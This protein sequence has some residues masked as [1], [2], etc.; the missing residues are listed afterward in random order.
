MGIFAAGAFDASTLTTVS[1]LA[2]RARADD[3]VAPFSDDL[4]AAVTDGRTELTLTL[5][6]EGKVSG[7]AFTA[8]QGD[9]L[10]AEL[11]VDPR[12]RRRGLG[13]LLVAQLLERTDGE[14][15]LWAHGDLPGA[16]V[17]AGRH[18]LERTRELLQLRRP[19]GP[20]APPLPD[21][22]LPDGVRI[23]TFVVGQDEPAWLEVNNAAFSWHPEQSG[24]TMDD[25][26][27]A[28]SAADFDPAGFFLAVDETDRI[29][30]FHWTKVHAHDPAAPDSGPIGEVYVVGVA[31][32]AHGRGLGAALTTTG[33][34]H[35][36][37]V[38]GV[39]TVQLYVEG[40]NAAALK[41]YERT[42]FARHL[43]DIAYRRG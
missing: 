42:G 41:V 6:D 24:Q 9:R 31:P 4:W 32:E 20:G 30:G 34:R 37:E 18:Q 3:G 22:R 39:E 15:W 28:E 7:V 13:G 2:D 10:A 40:D 38:A 12:Q 33:L 1:E 19:W 23:R 21:V 11:V 17:L 26:R 14:L 29:L 16:R 36:A 35:L 8:L 27:A 25:I 5:T 43:V